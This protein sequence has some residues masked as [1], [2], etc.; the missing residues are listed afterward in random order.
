MKD[1]KRGGHFRLNVRW[2]QVLIPLVL[3][4]LAACSQ[5]TS[6]PTASHA[7]AVHALPAVP[8]TFYEGADDLEPFTPFL[9]Q[10]GPNG[11]M[12]TFGYAEREGAYYIA[13]YSTAK[14][15]ETNISNGFGPTDPQWACD[16]SPDIS[17]TFTPDVSL[18][19]R[20]C[21][22]GSMTIFTLPNALSVYHITGSP[23]DVSLAARS[24]VAEFSP[25]NKTLAL[26]DDGPGGPG[27]SIM[28]LTTNQWQTVRTITLA[29]SL[30]SRPAWSPDS[31]R[32]AEV[33]L[34]G[35]LHILDAASGQDV[36]SATLP[37][38]IEANAASD[39]A[40]PA[41][42]WSPDGTTLTVTTPATTG[43]VLSTW[44]VHGST[45]T[46]NA[47]ATL[48]YT[49]DAAN[50]QLSPDGMHLFVHTA[51][52]H[53][54]IFTLPDLKQVGDFALPG[55]LTVWSDAQHLDS[56]TLQ[57]TVVVLQVG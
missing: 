36:A 44:A 52:N 29:A 56:F 39:P 40:G 43:T 3:L 10:A 33:D 25:D 16:Q 17:T 28:L 35:K 8:L 19:A 21:G 47:T 51:T 46:L 14:W 11:T 6:H 2:Q 22:D 4:T 41:P 12:L 13:T 54:Q 7:L 45:L 30:L 18:M 23:D 38:F 27:Q 55:S 32:I 9:A 42:Q 15:A 5:G 57:A 48:A 24:P 49:P 34:A 20:T 1:V 37:Q 50:P 31:T 26:T 53:G